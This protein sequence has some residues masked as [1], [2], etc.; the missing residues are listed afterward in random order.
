MRHPGNILISIMLSLM[1]VYLGA[2][3]VIMHCMH[4]DTVQIGM[5]EDCCDCDTECGVQQKCMEMTVM[6]LSPTTVTSIDKAHF[7][8]L[9]T[10]VKPFCGFSYS[11]FHSK[12]PYSPASVVAS[13]TH[14]PPRLYLA[15][16]RV[17]II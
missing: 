9:F 15:I 13:V 1:V 10:L 2:G 6:K 12:K 14:A 7:M 17:L 16:I 4:D 8:P 5:T 11:I 3:T